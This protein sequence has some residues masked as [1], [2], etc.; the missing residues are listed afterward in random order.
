LKTRFT[1]AVLLAFMPLFWSQAAH[2]EEVWWAQQNNEHE[3]T[4]ITAPEGW[5]FVWGRAWY[6]DPNDSTCGADVSNDFLALINGTTSSVIRVTNDT[7]GDPCSGTEKVLRFTWGIIPL[8][9]IYQPE[10]E[11]T[12]APPEPSPTPVA[13]SPEPITPT[14]AP[15]PPTPVVEPTQPAPPPEPAPEPEPI[16][17]PAPEPE[18]IPEPAPEPAPQPPTPVEEAPLPPE[19]EPE[20]PPVEPTPEPEPP[21]E[22][23]M[24]ELAEAAI[25][26]DPVVPEALA[27]IPLLGDAAVAVLEAFNVLGN[28]GA[29]MTPEVREKSEDVI[30][31]SVIAGQIAT[32]A[33]AAAVSAASV[34]RNK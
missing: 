25:A 3:I 8:P 2:A 19:V 31:A 18:P 9:V 4:G 5:Q 15:E 11:P 7:F 6:G 24:A 22:E 27:A 29:D 12:P 34:R 28:V 26:D 10:P 21:A 20:A 23:V 17:E 32:T 33:S 14:P 1:G 16:P 13:P 30:V